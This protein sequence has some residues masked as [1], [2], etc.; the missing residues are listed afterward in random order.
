MVLVALFWCNCDI[1]VTMAACKATKKIEFKN[2]HHICILSNN[3]ATTPFKLNNYYL[4][5][6]EKLH[7]YTKSFKID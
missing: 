3:L 7:V 5:L 4:S 6:M 1:Y 2:W